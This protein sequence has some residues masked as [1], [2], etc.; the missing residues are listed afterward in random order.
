MPQET[1]QARAARIAERAGDRQEAA[2]GRRRHCVSP[3]ASPFPTPGRN[4]GFYVGTL[5]VTVPVMVILTFIC[6]VKLVGTPP[7]NDCPVM[8]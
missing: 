2:P 5:T 4:V 1:P 3:E 6:Q 8:W 7:G